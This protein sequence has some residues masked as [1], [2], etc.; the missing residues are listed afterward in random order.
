MRSARRFKVS[1]FKFKVFRNYQ[2]NPFGS[3]LDVL[4]IFIQLYAK[5]MG[6]RPLPFLRNEPIARRAGSKFPCS[7]FKAFRNLRN[8]AINPEREK[9]GRGER[10]KITKRSHALGSP[11]QSFGFKVRGCGIFAK[12]SQPRERAKGGRGERGKGSGSRASRDFTK[13]SH[14]SLILAVSSDGRESQSAAIGNYETNPLGGQKGT[15]KR[16]S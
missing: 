1:G 7:R 3:A 10:E 12:R 13:R 8:E 9:G 6:T 5:Q 14:S 15:G 4:S 16:E 2:T 11:V